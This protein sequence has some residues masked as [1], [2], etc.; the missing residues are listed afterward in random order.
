MSVALVCAVPWPN[1]GVGLPVSES[2]ACGTPVLTSDTSSLPEVAG[3]AA[4]L[5][6]PTS[7]EAIAD[8]LHQLVTDSVLR[9]RL[10][11]AGFAN[12]QRFSWQRCARETLLVLEQTAHGD[13]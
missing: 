3:E 9:E 12:I 2:L 4:L 10:R 6:D 13:L 7:T 5:V 11:S 8:G 1:E